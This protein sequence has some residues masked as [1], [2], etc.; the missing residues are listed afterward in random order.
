[1]KPMKHTMTAIAFALST[2]LAGA[3][4]AQG[5][6]SPNSTGT[7]T[8]PA[9]TQSTN[10]NTMSQGDQSQANWGNQAQATPGTQSAPGVQPN[11]GA[12]PGN[13]SEAMPN[14]NVT[15]GTQSQAMPNSNETNPSAMSGQNE[16]NL[17]RSQI[18][19]AQTQLKQDG[20]YNGPIDGRMGPETH[21]AIRKYQEQNGLEQSANLD[22]QTLQH[23]INHAQRG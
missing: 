17:S 11:V 9:Q 14:A 22:Q 6:M 5:A 8:P 18:K 21:A 23:L 20:L 15:P 13:Q 12:T 7:A 19:Q 10:P 3:A 2:G 1:M 16:A 4:F